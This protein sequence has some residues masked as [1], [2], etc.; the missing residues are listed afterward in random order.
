MTNTSEAFKKIISS[1]DLDNYSILTDSGFEKVVKLHKTI[2]YEIYELKLV[3]GKFLRCADNHIV[4]YMEGFE[5]F[6]VFVKDLNPGDKICING[7]GKLYETEV[8]SI[9]PTGVFEEMYDFELSKNSN[10]RYYTNEIL[11]HNTAIAE[12]LALRIYQKKVDRSL[13]NKKI[14]ELNI[15]S[16]IS[17]TKYR[18][19]FE[20]RMD[21]IMTEVQ[22]NPDVIIFID[23]I[24]N[25]IGA[26][27]ASGSMDAANII[28]PA[29]ARGEMRCIGATTIDEYKKVIENIFLLYGKY[30]SN[31]STHPRSSSSGIFGLLDKDFN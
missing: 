15:T 22:K 10:H 31:L 17:G 16:I 23:E 13:L 20:Q 29:L 11:S 14:I 6:E 12:G 28:K 21:E 24:H 7:D 19:D 8:E 25:V 9:T 2:P 30:C 27:S 26:G 18:G 1:I 5:L 4:F 3:D